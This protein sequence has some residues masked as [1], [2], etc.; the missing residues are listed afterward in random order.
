MTTHPIKVFLTVW[1]LGSAPAFAADE[2]SPK[3]P[4]VVID[5]IPASTGVYIGSPSIAIL[6]NGDYVASHDHFGPKTKEHESALTAVFRSADR[7]RTWTKVSEINGAFW[8]SL[9]VHRGALYLLGPHK[10]HGNILIRRSTDGGSTWTTPTNDTNGVLRDNGEYHCAPMPVIE[11]AGRLWRAFEWRH[12]PVAWGINYRAGM[13]SAPVDADLLNAAS[14]TLAEPLPS[15]RAWN[16]GDM[17]AWLEGNAVV[18]PDGGMVDVLRV[19]TTSPDEKAA[20]VHVN[21][22]GRHMS[23]DPATGFVNFPGGAKKFTIRQ[24]PQSKLYWSLANSIPERH[25][26]NNAGGIRNTL[27]LTCSPDLIHWTVRCILLY[28]PDTAVHGFQYVD[29]QFDGNDIIAACRTAYDDGKG[30]AHNFHDANY[31]TF[32]RVTGFR[33]LT[34]ADSVPFTKMPPARAETAE[35]IITGYGWKLA[36]LA[37]GEQAFA[38]RTYA[39][40]NVPEKFRGW[41]VT[42]TS[43]GEHADLRVKAKSDTTLFIA[44]TLAQKAVQLGGW[45]IVADAAFCYTDKGRTPMRIFSRALKAGEEISVPQGNWTGTLALVPSVVFAGRTQPVATSSQSPITNLAEWKKDRPVALPGATRPKVES[46]FIYQPATEWTYSH[47]PGIT[48]F[49]GRFYAI[50][51]NGRKDEDAPGQRVLMATA[52][53]FNNW[54][55]PRPLVDSMKDEKGVERVLTAAGF[56]QHDGTLVAYFGNYGPHKE[57]THL[58]AV[59]TTDGEHW[60]AVREMGVPVNPNHGP[61]PIASGRLIICGN[62]SFPFT[63]DPAGLAGWRMSGIYPKDM[64]ATIKDDPESFWEVAKRQGWPAGLCEGSFYQTNDGVLHMLLRNAAT[65]PEPYRSRL[66]CAESRNDGATWSEPVETNFSDTNSKFHCG[67]LPD[68]RLYVVSNPIGGGRT[69]LVLSLSRDGV[70]FDHHFILGDT[71]Y[72]Q[73]QK[74][75]W[76]GG[77]YGYP[78]SIVHEGRLYVIVSRQK[79]AVEVL[80]VALTELN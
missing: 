67:R 36:T 26:A 49:K 37:D 58:Q 48:F 14:W 5:H 42:Q 45:N 12:P 10:H 4:G 75:R 72:E 65:K 16:G 47:H 23:F 2:P 7:G 22:D 41:R 78:H 73:R 29:W 66:W 18:A 80:R 8:S 34:M 77:E 70:R 15:D 21:A 6:P 17:G 40:K 69:P 39:W 28:H 38:N 11:H 59:T 27:A 79:E 35:F 13:L 63:D 3:V 74:G 51:S 31:L 60:S 57:T 19:Q 76:K 54:A 32:H 52:S 1:A 9:F 64:A 61:Q 24:D 33:Q 25:R 55:A 46:V 71:H 20:I 53:D 30:G 43:G 68:G 62:I 56:H 50:W 44:T